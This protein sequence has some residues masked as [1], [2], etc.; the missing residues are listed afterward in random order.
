MSIPFGAGSETDNALGCFGTFERSNALCR[1][2]CALRLKCVIE[3]NNNIR[4]ELLDEWL[5]EQ[6]E[7]LK[8]Q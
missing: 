3:Q 4:M 8:I 7:A 5:A 2:Y 6:D 1:N